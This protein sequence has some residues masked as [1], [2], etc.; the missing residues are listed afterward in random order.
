[1]N[2][3]C[4]YIEGDHLQNCAPDTVSTG[5]GSLPLSYV[6]AN[7]RQTGTATTGKLP[8][9]ETLNGKDSYIK[10]LQHFTTT[11]ETPDEIY[12]LG[13][14]MLNKLYSE[15]RLAPVS[16]FFQGLFSIYQNSE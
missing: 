11:S 7:G 6:Y 2:R 4:R 13:E 9:G 1:M 5:F 8:T 12:K 15:V 16:G 14:E 10:L 3:L